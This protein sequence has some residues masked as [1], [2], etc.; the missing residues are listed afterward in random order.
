MSILGIDIGTT[1]VSFAV[2]NEESRILERAVTVANGS[3]IQ[4]EEPWEKL[5]DA[6]LLEEKVIGKAREL[7]LEIPHISSIGLTG[8]MHGILYVDQRGN[9]VSPLYTWQDGRGNQPD[10]GG[11]SLTACILEEYGEEVYTGYG[12]LTQLY[13]RRK[14]IV[15]DTAVSFCTIADYIGMK[16]TDRKSPLLH[17]SMAASLGFFDAGKKQFKRDILE[18]LGAGTDMAPE[19]TDKVSPLGTFCGVPVYTVIGDNQA[20]VL[21]AAGTAPGASLI[22][23][24]TGGQISVV[25]DRN[26]Q[27]PGIETRP[28]LDGRYILVGAS[29]CGGRAYA[30]LENFF[31]QYMEAA[32][33]EAC[34]QY[35]IMEKILEEA[36]ISRPL[37]VRTTFQG[38]RIKPD[39]RGSIE[40]IGEDNFTPAALIDGV[41]KG[42][43][44]ELY[45]MYR[46]IAARTGLE[47]EVIYASGNGIRKNRYLQKAFEQAFGKKVILAPYQEEAACGA[48]MSCLSY[49]I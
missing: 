22:N 21:G 19:V 45:D 46:E 39:M 13:N 9:C 47:T 37:K 12:W 41:L 4:T 7:L 18:A 48:A 23:M 15:P 31:R 36:E 33:L 20:S 40:G 5:Q 16:L 35:G 34:A 32:G 1:S 25:T 42:M 2:L 10:F 8:Q 49:F 24:G 3:F 38:T 26:I 27:V 17:S 30:I 11:R 28:Y 43:A 14:N 6:A 44:G 29:L